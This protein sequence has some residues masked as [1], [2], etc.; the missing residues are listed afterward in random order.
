[1][2]VGNK[3]YRPGQVIIAGF[4]GTI[5]LG[6]LL[7][8]LPIATKSG[9]S[10]GFFDALFTATSA[11][12]VTGLVLHDTYTYW[13]TFGQ[14]I[15]L[16]LIQIGG[17]GVVTMAIAVVMFTGKRIGLNERFLMQESISA[18]QV[19]G[20]IR[21]TGFILR[22]TL[23]IEGLGALFLALRFCPTMGLKGIWFAV[24][25]SISAFCN[26][27]FDLMGERGA[28]SSL[29]SYAADPLIN[30][31]IMALIVVG[32]IGFFVWDD[33]R[34]HKTNFHSYRLH[35]KVVLLTTTILLVLPAVLLFCFEFSR[36]VW[37][38]SLW[39]QFWASVF[40]TVTPRTAGF[41]TVDLTML[42]EPTIFLMVL[43]MV[44]G[45]SPGST[46]GGYKTTTLAT[47][48]LCMRSVFRGQDHIQIFGRR[49]PQDVLRRSVSLFCL[50]LILFL[51]G[52]MVISYIEEIPILTAIFETGSAIG[53][54][55]LS[56]GI[57]PTL[58]RCSQLIL[59]LLMFFGRVG[60]LTLI[61]AISTPHSPAMAQL[62]QEKI[63]IG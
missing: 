47:L 15:I 17:M 23:F 1:M 51:C 36:D 20:I 34:A 31:T 19:G 18:P 53:T 54:V 10:A 11:T 55:G 27:G 24:F 16:M 22:T 38:F 46:A 50:Y 6:A 4:G 52:G 49:F 45:G 57:T 5:L 32:G 62:P 9:T 29:T 8:T 56:L 35:S 43:L 58:G 13:S 39:E 7:L 40:Q 25:H 3:K 14:V 33:I 12:C 61:Y 48:L 42:S 26:A 30:L 28:F 21:L 37:H 63:T 41:N 2:F 59:I 44:T 60:G